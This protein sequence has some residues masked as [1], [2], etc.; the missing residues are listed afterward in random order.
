M[1]SFLQHFVVA[2]HG[3]PR[4]SAPTTV[5]D[6]YARKRQSKCV[7]DANCVCRKLMHRCIY[8][9][10][11]S[12]QTV[13]SLTGLRSI[14][15]VNAL[16]AG[17]L[18]GPGRAVKL[19]ATS[20]VVVAVVGGARAATVAPPGNIYSKEF[21]SKLSRDQNATWGSIMQLI[22]TYE[23]CVH[24]LRGWILC[25]VRVYRLLSSSH[26]LRGVHVQSDRKHASA[27]RTQDY[28][29]AGRKSG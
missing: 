24:H 29:D 23:K 10:V 14:A 6:L 22:D 20:V 16:L 25:R 21:I 4:S 28:E 8:A 7:R 12:V 19:F 11:A 15:A 17:Y 2:L 27:Q 1:R 18:L 26:H 3:C 5:C 13:C 9:S